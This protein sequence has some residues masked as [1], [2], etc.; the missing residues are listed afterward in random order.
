LALP[1]ALPLAGC[2]TSSQPKFP[3]AT[4]VPAL[5]DGGR[6]VGYERTSDGRF[7][8]EESFDVR[9]RADGGYDF[10]DAKGKATTLSL[11]RIGP[12]RFVAQASEEGG[13]HYVVLQVRGDEVLAFAPDC[14]EQ[15]AAKLKAQGVHV[16]Q[17]ECVIDSVADPAALFAG[18]E[19][20]EPGS[21][22]VREPP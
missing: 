9:R 8:R 7:K 5:G 17:Y 14:K 21:K 16:R 3:L 18:M 20:G 10:I 19:L 11:H 6:Y 13:I 15:D 2:F 1:L 4:A 22:M 12:D